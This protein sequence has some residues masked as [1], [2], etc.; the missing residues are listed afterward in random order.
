MSDGESRGT[1]RWL[2]DL[3]TAHKELRHSVAD[4]QQTIAGIAVLGPERKAETDRRL[5]QIDAKLNELDGV[6]GKLNIAMEDWKSYRGY[7]KMIFVAIGGL[8]LNQLINIKGV[9]HGP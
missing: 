5:A 9:F 1:F 7:I 4:I 3:E 8:V 2:A 6:I